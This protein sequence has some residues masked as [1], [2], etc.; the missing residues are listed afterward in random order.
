MTVEEA[1]QASFSQNGGSINND[2]D[3]NKWARRN[4][5]EAVRTCTNELESRLL[6]V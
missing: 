4:E 5:T 3:D 2:D 6:S 1:G